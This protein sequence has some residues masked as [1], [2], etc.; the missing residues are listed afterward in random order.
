MKIL[1]LRLKNLNSLQGEWKI[2]FSAEPFASNGLFAITGPTGAGKTTLLDAIC[3]AL[4]HQTPRLEI[5]AN[6]NELMTRH[7]SES[8]A[9]VEF[10]VKGIGYR[11]FW[12]QRRAKNDP[13][14]NLQ[15]PKVELALREDGKILA[16]KISD[17]KELIASITGLDFGRF[18]KSM[19]L[20][21]GQF[22]AFLNAKPNERAELLEEL[23]GTEIYGQLSSRVF[24]QHKQA[25]A[26]LDALH[27]R[28]NGIELLNDEQHQ[29]LENQLS[30]LGNEALSINQQLQQQQHQ[31][32]WLQQWHSTEQQVQRYQQQLVAVQQDYQQAEPQLLRLARSEP[33]EKLR[34]LLDERQRCQRDNLILQQQLEQ[35]EQQQQRQATELFPLQQRLEQA[36]TAKQA[37]NSHNQQ[38][39]TLIDKQVQPLDQQIALLRTTLAEV[40]KHRDGSWQQSEKQRLEL[41]QL[42]AKR[43][44]LA[45]LAGQYQIKQA[46]L[47]AALDKQ[48]QQQAELETQSPTEKLRHRQ[49]ELTGLRPLRQQLSELALLFA[50]NQQQID[51][52]QLEFAAN[53]KQLAEIEAQLDAVRLQYKQQKAHQTDVEKVLEMEKRIVS[54]EAERAHLQAEMPCPLCGSTY[55]PAIEQYQALK[56]S[57]TEQRAAELR[58]Q[59]DRLHTL[60]TELRARC[61]SLK[62]QQQRLQPQLVQTLAQRE[63]HLQ[64][65]LSLTAPLAFDFTL[66]EPDRLGTWLDACESEEQANQQR[67]QQHQQAIVAVQQAKDT[68][69]TLRGEQQS[70]QQE[71]ARLNER[72][73]LLEISQQETQRLL[74]QWQQRCQ[75]SE[76]TLAELHGKRVALFGE[77]SIPEV[78]EQLQKA[79]S[80][81]EKAEQQASEQL[82]K[83]QEQRDILAGQRVTLHQQQQQQ[84]ERLLRAEQQWLQALASSTF[85][86]EKQLLAALLDDD[87]RQLLQQR[88]EQ[89]QQRQVEAST[90]LTQAVQMLEQQRLNRPVNLDE[91]TAD[92]EQLTTA[93]NRLAEQLKA[94][95]L[96]QGEIS[97]QLS[98]NAQRRLNQQSLFEQIAQS[99]QQYDD[100][101]QLNQLIGSKDGDKFRKFAQGLTLDHLV[102]LAN[103]QL[104][105]LHGR[106]LLQ[107]KIS[108]TLELQVVDTWQADVLRDTRT[109]S[110]GESFLVSLALALALSDLVSHKTSID[111]LFLDEGFGTLDAETLDTA[112]DALDSLNATGKTIGVISHV[113]AM[114]ERIP[115]QIKVKKVNGLGVSRLDERFRVE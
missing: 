82:Q 30:A 48:L 13:D 14:G 66:Q 69:N 58:S 71:V 15:A 39:Q 44:Q 115:V 56:P 19:M 72:F 100:W 98:S 105:R 7:T 24:E 101:S 25:K 53:Q 52:Q 77:Q 8:L 42:S 57:E 59:T 110:G 108:E 41:E 109:L 6:Q 78:R 76:T 33:A 86:D 2:D 61:D 37:Q 43:T 9:E 64:S 80:A 40:Q 111:S 95:Q 83:A 75:D 17:K 38:Q 63:E 45:A 51:R 36:K 93:L 99:Q 26:E 103:R 73:E 94:L 50:Q 35:L 27:H 114:K 55:H 113:D 90:L 5:S 67:L 96:H 88:K 32:N 60:G 1:S 84:T 91:T 11:A 104:S 87:T 46:E 112:L 18:T 34:P 16:D 107:R 49:A 97:N 85:D 79:L 102:Y 89:L 21:Q 68:L 29:T 20:S 3:L 70:S 65:W 23:T 74:A 54:L 92:V 4:Y 31:L 47:T 28:A 62:E 10:E 12:S 81:C 22:A 106:Y